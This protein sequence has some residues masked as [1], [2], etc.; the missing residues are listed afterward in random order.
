MEV[1]D[2]EILLIDVLFSSQKAE[3]YLFIEFEYLDAH[4]NN[5]GM[6]ILMYILTTL[7]SLRIVQY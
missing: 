6:F 2:F 7:K 5:S 1:N 3:K 4:I